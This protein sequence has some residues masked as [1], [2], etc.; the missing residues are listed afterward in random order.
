MIILHPRKSKRFDKFGGIFRYV[1]PLNKS[2]VFSAEDS[3]KNVLARTKAVDVF[4]PGSDIE[5][6][7]EG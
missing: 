6:A 1:L 7:D 3:Q 2:V 4:L 5:K